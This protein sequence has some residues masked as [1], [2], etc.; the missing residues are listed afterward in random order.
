MIFLCL[1]AI[2]KGKGVDRMEKYYLTTPI[3]YPSGYLHIGNTYTT[4][5]ADMFKRYKELQGYDVYLVTGSDEHG[6]KIQKN[7]EK[8]GVTPLEFVTNINKEIYK[9][10]DLLD[11]KIDKYIRTSDDSHAKVVEHIFNQ[12]YEQGDIYKGEYEGLYCTPCESFWTESQLVDGKCPDCGREVHAA[13]EEAYFFRLSK[14]KDRLLKYYEEHPDFIMPSSKKAE[15][16]NNFFKDGLQDLCVSRTS[17]DWGVK[18]PFDPKHVVYVWIDALSSYIDAAGYLQDDEKF[19][20]LWPADL[21]FVGK[22]ILRFHVII[23]PALLMALNLPLPKQVFGH[24]W[25]LF[26]SDKMSKSKG[27]VIYPEPIVK[28]Y[29]RDALKYYVLREFNFGSDGN[30]QSKKFMER[31]NS[32]LANDLGNLVSRTIAMAEKYFD[33]KV[34]KKTSD[35]KFDKELIDVALSRKSKL[36]EKMKEFDL[37]V[38]IDEVF[39]LIKRSNKYIDETCP[40]TLK[41]ED[42]RERLETII[43]NL[44]ESLRIASVL[45]SPF[46]P[47]SAKK[48]REAL[49]LS[50]E[51]DYSECDEF[52]KVETYT[53]KKIETLFPRLDVDKEVERLLEENENLVKSRAEEDAKKHGKKLEEKPAK[54]EDAKAAIEYDDFLKL[55]LRLGE[56]IASKEHPEADKL[57]INTIKIGDETRTIVSGIKKWYKPEDLIGKKVVVVCNLKPRKLRGVESEGMILACENGDDLSIVTT[58]EDMPSGSL[59]G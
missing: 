46:I 18:V 9:L 13:H 2:I 36:D 44:L 35:D 20:K 40:W 7:A 32:D 28:L 8:E 55:D 58:L 33:G 30:F 52:G 16:V 19:N 3:Y 10:W 45:L 41:G 24:G 22:D 50:E 5:V 26:E 49:G 56:I 1:Y 12:L 4:I 53:V 17:F 37:S 38:A 43:Y 34:S 21:H 11:I 15:M 31:V 57:L 59:I 47:D 14:Y 6:E 29:G 54:A 23:W 39:K 25:I 27:N 48:I 51:M 42:E